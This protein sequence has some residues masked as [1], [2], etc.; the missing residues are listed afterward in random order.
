MILR[1]GTYSDLRIELT[2]E[3]R[4]RPYRQLI[5]EMKQFLAEQ[6]GADKAE[7]HEHVSISDPGFAHFRKVNAE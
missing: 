1:N 2:V 5:D 4:S 3:E 6:L 7:S